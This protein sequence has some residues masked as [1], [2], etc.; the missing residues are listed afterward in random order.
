MKQTREA[1]LRAAQ[2]QLVDHG[3]TDF[4]IPGLA[5]AAGVSV[6]TIYRY[7]PTKDALLQDLAYWIDDQIGS[8]KAPRTLDEMMDGIETIFAAFED[9]ESLMRAQW[10]TTQGRLLREK[11]RFRRLS[12]LEGTVKQSLPNLPPG[13]LRRAT[14]ILSLLLSSRTWQALKDDFGMDGRESGKLITWATRTL[15]ADLRR[16][17]A[18]AA[19][20]RG[21]INKNK[22]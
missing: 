8:P 12:A 11:G 20:E 9:N 15:V 3:F 4:N 21:F 1:I 13:E 6:R 7:F 5:E 10:L 16:R 22:K 19:L 14:A 17:D 18:E 2:E